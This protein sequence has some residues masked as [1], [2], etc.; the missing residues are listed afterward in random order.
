MCQHV[1]K[2]E[3]VARVED[4]IDWHRP[5]TIKCIAIVLIVWFSRVCK[6]IDR[7]ET[8]QRM[9]PIRRSNNMQRMPPS[10]GISHC[11]FQMEGSHWSWESGIQWSESTKNFW[12]EDAF[13]PVV[14]CAV[15]N[16]MALTSVRMRSNL[17]A[18]RT[19]SSIGPLASQSTARCNGSLHN[20]AKQ[21]NA[22]RVK[23]LPTPT[24][25]VIGICLDVFGF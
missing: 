9:T 15:G 23:L 17:K 12:S 18:N 19:V 20:D 8:L 24:G 5:G 13:A 4:F 14:F 21:M 25:P 10:W 11:S 2:I 7:S 6:V 16:T 1:Y 3:F 22:T